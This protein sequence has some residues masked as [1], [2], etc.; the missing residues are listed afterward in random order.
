MVS[1][2]SMKIILGAHALAFLN[3]SLTFAAHNHTNISINSEPEAEI[4]GTPASHATALASNVLP[5]PG[6]Q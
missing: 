4:N 2:S 5:A 6:G 3:K 1:I